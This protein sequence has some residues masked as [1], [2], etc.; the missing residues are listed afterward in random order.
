VDAVQA[1]DAAAPVWGNGAENGVS[2]KAARNSSD[3]FIAKRYTTRIL[4]TP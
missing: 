2:D 3:P 1:A 4:L